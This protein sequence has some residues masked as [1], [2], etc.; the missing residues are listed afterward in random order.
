MRHI[1]GLI[2]LIVCLALGSCLY[3][4]QHGKYFEQ[5]SKNQ[6][7]EKKLNQLRARKEQLTARL[8]Q[9]K[10]PETI[11]QTAQTMGLQK[12]ALGHVKRVTKQ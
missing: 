4:S 10:D 8:A 6:A 7:L 11:K 5:T 2:G 3:V 1:L 12:V 9:L